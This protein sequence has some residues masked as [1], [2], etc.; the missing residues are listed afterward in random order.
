MLDVDSGVELPKPWV[1]VLDEAS[2]NY[3]YWNE[4]TDETTW[5]RPSETA[6]KPK[7]EDTPPPLPPKPQIAE[8][9]AVIRPGTGERA[10]AALG[11]GATYVGKGFGN[12]ARKAGDLFSKNTRKHDNEKDSQLD[13]RVVH[14]TQKTAQASSAAAS[15]VVKGF[16]F[17]AK[18]ACKG[19]KAVQKRMPESSEPESA[20]KK[21]AK[22]AAKDTFKGI[23]AAYKGTKEGFKEAGRGGRDATTTCVAHRY[24]SQAGEATSNVFA[25]AKGVGTVTKATTVVGA[26]KLC[27][28][29]HAASKEK[30]TKEEKVSA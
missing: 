13:P 30:K 8:K 19:A 10:G 6:A 27:N 2:E 21:R 12:A 4:D 29:G 5:D 11:A 24:G 16:G 7:E 14:A 3:Y 22:A 26:A 1:A 9:N 23:Y 25:T 15:A 18:G 28:K 20:R 17:L